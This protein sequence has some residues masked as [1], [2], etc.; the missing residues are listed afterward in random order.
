MK[1]GKI[2]NTSWLRTYPSYYHFK[3]STKDPYAEIFD[4]LKTAIL[5]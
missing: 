1:L 4:D 2:K 5:K 3:E